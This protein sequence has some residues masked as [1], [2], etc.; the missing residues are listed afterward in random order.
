MTKTRT[1]SRGGRRET[2]VGLYLGDYSF[3]SWLWQHWVPVFNAL[4]VQWTPVW[5]R[6]FL[7]QEVLDSIS[8]L[9]V[10]GGFSWSSDMAFGGRIG[11]RRLRQEVAK[12][13]HYVGTCYGAN[14]AM[15]SGTEKRIC[16][17]GLVRGETLSH[18][19]FACRGTACIDYD[20]DPLGYQALSQE[21]A[22]VNG[23]IFGEGEY[24]VLG[25]FSA[26]Q[27]GPFETKPRR[28][29]SGL[30]AAI[31]AQHGAGRV[32]LFSSHPEIPTSYQYRSVLAQ[33][34]RRELSV[35]DAVPRCWNPP[36]VTMANMQLLESLFRR[37]RSESTR[38]WR[39]DP[40]P[41]SAERAA[42]LASGKELLRLGLL[43]IE[44]ALLTHL[45]HAR[46]PCLQ[47]AA[48]ILERRL[49]QARHILSMLDPDS[50]WTDP[51][52]FEATSLVFMLM[53]FA[54]TGD[55]PGRMKKFR[56]DSQVSQARR[57]ASL[58][59]RGRERLETQLAEL[60][61]DR[62]DDLVKLGQGCALR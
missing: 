36:A 30:P 56:L 52:K 61:V 2:R 4:Q 44:N 48:T 39:E 45:R 12:G 6:S 60:V 54:V 47:F 21:T 18:R 43:E 7:S 46:T 51:A 5:D 42:L 17:L 16:H 25:R 59:G 3:L 29:I 9:L 35:D 40:V 8:A 28:P 53:Q 10:P 1:D 34:A 37:I 33:I 49:R 15:A 38:R 31:A 19:T 24:E 41:S 26:N 20:A 13:M 23:R 57:M 55:H 50:L 58:E 62:L 32:F 14:V 22:H 11:R 27:P